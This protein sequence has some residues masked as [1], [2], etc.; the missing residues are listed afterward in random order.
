[1]RDRTGW[2]VM[3]I[4]VALLTTLG[5]SLSGLIA[6][7]RPVPT[8][9]RT[10]RP[11]FTPTPVTPELTEM[12][13]APQMA[14]QQEQPTP[15]PEPPTPTPE[16]PTP[17]PIPTPF[18]VVN[19]DIVNLRAGPGTNYP[20]VGKA[21]AGRTFT[22]TGKNP[23]GDWWEIC[24]VGNQRAWIYGQI[25]RAQGAVDTVSVAE[26]IPPPPPT[27]RPRPTTPPPPTPTPAPQYAFNAAGVE[28]RT[29]TNNLVT[30]WGRVFNQNRTQAFGGYKLRILRG[31]ATVAEATTE[32]TFRTGDP[33][34]GSEFR[35]NAKIEIF[36]YSAGQYTVQ[37]LDSGGQ[38]AG[39]DQ[40]FTVSGE[41]R[42]FLVEWLKR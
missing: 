19:E 29:T 24:C 17:T 22:I 13:P 12:Q 5:C 9:T 36:N 37:L 40:T 4:I 20:A 8:P 42:V 33:G 16:P 30:V 31:G 1:M 23:A 35:Y 3:L 10:P 18:V 21:Q 11:T 25:V 2:T 34:L 39:P 28:P 14:A 26:R 38:P 6:R 15:T 7:P 32:S 27:P 41:T